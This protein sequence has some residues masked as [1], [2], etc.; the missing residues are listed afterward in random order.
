MDIGRIIRH[1]VIGILGCGWGVACGAADP[2][3]VG[4]AEPAP[5]AEETAQSAAAVGP[6]GTCFTDCNTTSDC[7]KSC[8]IN[9][10]Q[11]VTTTCGAFGVC[12]PPCN[13]QPQ[14]APQFCGIDYDAHIWGVRLEKLSEVL[15]RAPGQSYCPDK[16]IQSVFQHTD[17]VG[18]FSQGGVVNCCT[19]AWGAECA[20]LAPR[21]H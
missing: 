16:Y 8:T 9:A 1:T 10:A 21:C 17:C 5:S 11:L 15:Y 14:T 12:R 13:Y 20:L 4:T 18:V 19:N 3:E 2:G 7:A 6:G